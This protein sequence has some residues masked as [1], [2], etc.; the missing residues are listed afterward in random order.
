VTDHAHS[1]DGADTQHEAH[2]GPSARDYV[3]IGFI[4]LIITIL[5][6]FASFL[7]RYLGVPMG[8]QIAILIALAVLKGAMVLMFFMHLRFDSRWFTFLM[9]TGL[10]LATFGII[11][12]E[13]LFRYRAGQVD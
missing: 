13:L 6:V 1:H 7:H 9:T 2:H 3:R 8:V 12:F 5:E 10:V 11:V 4:L